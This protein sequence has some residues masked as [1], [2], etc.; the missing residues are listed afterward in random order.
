MSVRQAISEHLLLIII[1][2]NSFR[3]SPANSTLV[4]LNILPNVEPDT[5]LGHKSTLMPY[6][7]FSGTGVLTQP[8]HLP[9][10]EPRLSS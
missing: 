8:R 6:L 9:S 10:R 7:A 1:G 4:D 5:V 2:L 3:S